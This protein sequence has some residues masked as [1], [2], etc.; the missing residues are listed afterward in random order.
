MPCTIAG[1]IAILS[2]KSLFLI[3][4]VCSCCLIVAC[5][6]LTTNRWDH[7]TLDKLSWELAWFM[8]HR[9]GLQESGA[10][11][12]RQHGISNGPWLHCWKNPCPT[13]ICKRSFPWSGP[14]GT[15]D[16]TL[17]FYPLQTAEWGM[18]ELQGSF[19]KLQALLGVNNMEKQADPTECCFHLYNLRMQLVGINQIRSVYIPMWQ[20]GE[21]GRVWEGF[22]NILF[23]DQWK[24]NCVS[25][26]HIQEEW[27]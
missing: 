19:G 5:L 2:V 22:E 23:S 4:K 9:G 6:T 26:F 8:C 20:E 12:T 17:M 27:Y 1:F 14:T 15:E 24:Y 7:C 3:L 16:A 18:Q 11:H 21:S 10:Q 25:T 13:Q